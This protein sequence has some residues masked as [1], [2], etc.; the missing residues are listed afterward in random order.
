MS[1]FQHHIVVVPWDEG[2]TDLRSNPILF[3]ARDFHKIKD[4]KGLGAPS[5]S[6]R[7]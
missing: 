7:S 6:T 5:L 1:R 3:S 4:M 2:V